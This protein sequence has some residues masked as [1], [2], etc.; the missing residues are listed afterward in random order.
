MGAA[1]FPAADV[2]Q[3]AKGLDVIDRREG[4]ARN[5]P[6]LDLELSASPALH[7]LQHAEL[8]ILPA[9]QFVGEHAGQRA[10]FPNLRRTQLRE[11]VGDIRVRVLALRDAARSRDDERVTGPRVLVGRHEQVVHLPSGVFLLSV[12]FRFPAG[13][14]RPC[15]FTGDLS[16]CRTT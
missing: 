13:P 3:D 10:E 6:V 12:R 7:V 9:T 14:T 1:Q 5:H 8:R 16:G 4:I 15:V 2:Q 11:A